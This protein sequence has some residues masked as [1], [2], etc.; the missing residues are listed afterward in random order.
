MALLALSDPEYQPDLDVIMHVL[1]RVSQS[2]SQENMSLL[3]LLLAQCLMEANSPRPD[4]YLTVRW[5]Q[6]QSAWEVLA[7]PTK[8]AD[9]P[10]TLMALRHFHRQSGP[11]RA[12]FTLIS[13]T[14]WLGTPKGDLQNS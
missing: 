8:R 13:A 5:D 6:L 1:R 11:L 9:I 7:H 14:A 3:F 4:N 12:G 10:D 2:T